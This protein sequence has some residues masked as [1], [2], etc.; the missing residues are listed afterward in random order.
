V[1]FKS[2]AEDARW[3]VREAAW[4]FEERVLWR[5]SDTARAALRRA[6]RA[7][8]PLQRLIQTKLVWPFSD[9]LDD[10]GT[11][12]RTAFATVG[13][14]AALGAGAAGVMVAGS[15]DG[16]PARAQA[17]ELVTQPGDAGASL[18]GVPPDFVADPNASTTTATAA[19]PAP[20]PAA[21]EEATSEP[22][23]VAW[24]F[25]RAFVRYEVGKADSEAV[26]TFDRFATKPLATALGKHPP[27]LPEGTK[28]PEARV[29][30]VV[31]G[32]QTGK[33]MTAS[34]SLV[35]LEAASEVRLNLL[36]TEKGWRV[37]GVLG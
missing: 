37:S 10:Y 11:G 24:T 30:N 6:L 27:R 15:G 20:P 12:A 25:A 28:V 22:G 33:E 34:V 26:A 19:K 1:S 14:V 31:L 4:T 13:V 29:L 17:A 9:R 3:G 32:E 2:S 8:S 7:V 36:E 16:V 23:P 5:A 18:Q 21:G 35:R